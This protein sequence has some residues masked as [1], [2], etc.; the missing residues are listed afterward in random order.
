VSRIGGGNES[1]V[2]R[3]ESKVVEWERELGERTIAEGENK[4]AMILQ[5]LECAHRGCA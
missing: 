1:K 4:N 5:C 2:Q 3:P